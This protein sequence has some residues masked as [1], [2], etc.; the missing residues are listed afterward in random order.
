MAT[1]SDFSRDVKSSAVVHTLSVNKR[2]WKLE[3]REGI[4][5]WVG[6]PLD[7]G[8]LCPCMTGI[9]V[10]WYGGTTIQFLICSTKDV[11]NWTNLVKSTQNT[12]PWEP[13]EASFA[14]HSCLDISQQCWKQTSWRDWLPFLCRW[15][16]PMF[17]FQHQ[18][19]QLVT[20]LSPKEPFH[21]QF[22]NL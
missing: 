9:D 18:Q 4:S 10:P 2:F 15:H 8:Q 6:S 12:V 3:S 17:S 5:K 16:G 11:M 7:L 22:G 1:M 19:V 21:G 13:C 14:G 20:R